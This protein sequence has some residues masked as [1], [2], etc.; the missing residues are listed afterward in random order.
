MANEVVALGLPTG[1]TLHAVCYTAA[2]A[3]NSTA[4]LTETASSGNYTNA[5][6]LP[7]NTAYY[8]VE[9]VSGNVYA[10]GSVLAG[11]GLTQQQVADSLK[12]APTVGAP[13]SGSAMAD[14]FAILGDTSALA[15]GG[16]NLA[17]VWGGYVNGTLIFVAGDAYSSTSGKAITIAKPAGAAWPA[18]LTGWTVTL[19]AAARTDL[20]A[21]GTRTL[22]TSVT[23]VDPASTQSLVI[24]SLAATVTALL[25]PGV[26]GWT[27]AI[28]AVSGT[29]QNTLMSGNMTV[30]A[31]A[32]VE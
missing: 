10:T 1:L 15:A 25:A 20:A 6:S 18:D 19:Q 21:A 16:T 7:A 8:E 28:V 27:F 29:D 2:L 24:E 31:L 13:A 3:S 14:L 9:D 12:L 30:A 17:V 23:V 5:G 22:S 26:N 4:A 32:T 11:S